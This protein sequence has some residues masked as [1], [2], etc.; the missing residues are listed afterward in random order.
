MERIAALMVHDEDGPFAE[1]ER[2][3]SELG[4]VPI[5]LRTLVEVK[6]FLKRL[7]KPALIF[8][9]VTLPDGTWADVVQE[10]K[11]AATPSPVI[12]VSRFVDLSLYLETLQKGAVDFIVAPVSTSQLESIIRAATSGLTRSPEEDRTAS[13]RRSAEGAGAASA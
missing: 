4:I 7:H 11:N 12:V 13:D 9:D 3:M 6:Y 1:L 2:R 8:T 10:A 5:G